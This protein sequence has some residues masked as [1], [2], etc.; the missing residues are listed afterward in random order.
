M[1][2]LFMEWEDSYMHYL[3]FSYAAINQMIAT[4]R[5]DHWGLWI[6]CKWALVNILQIILTC[7]EFVNWIFIEL[8]N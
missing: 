2:S 7:S 8:K 3:E 6:V 1:S 5:A 4:L